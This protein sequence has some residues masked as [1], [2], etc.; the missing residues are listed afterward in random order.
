MAKTHMEGCSIPLINREILIETPR[1]Y[2][3]AV[4]GMAIEKKKIYKNGCWRG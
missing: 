2:D 4:V 1:K 3:I